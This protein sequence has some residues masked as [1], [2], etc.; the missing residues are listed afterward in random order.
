VTYNDNTSSSGSVPT[1][2]ASYYT[3]QTVP[4]LSN[5]GN[6][7][8]T[9]YSFGGWN[10]AANGSGTT[11]AVGETFSMGSGNTTLYAYWK[12]NYTQDKKDYNPS[13]TQTGE[14]VTV[15][16]SEADFAATYAQN[17]FNGLVQTIIPAFFPD[18][19]VKSSCT[20]SIK[21]STGAGGDTLW[22]TNDDTGKSYALN[23]FDASGKISRTD[24][25]SD[26]TGTTRTGYSVYTLNGD[27]TYQKVLTY[28]DGDVLQ[29]SVYFIFSSGLVTQIDQWSGDGTGT[30][31]RSL[32]ITYD[33]SN[34]G[35][36]ITYQVNSVNQLQLVFGFTGTNV[37]NSSQEIYSWSGSDWTLQ[38][39]MTATLN[40]S[41][42]RTTHVSLSPPWGGLG[43]A[44]YTYTS[45]DY[46]QQTTV[47][48]DTAGTTET[49]YSVYTYN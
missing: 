20:V 46:N 27:G 49:G 12:Q 44:D 13:A 37:T 42:T 41:G 17:N 47:Y 45:S 19:I 48:S 36:N 33:T 5:S 38:S 23:T 11:Y 30:H 34:R 39:T 10:T 21:S 26:Y 16:T 1:D 25:Y 4:V 9:G 7:K 43:A 18:S 15:F 32:T 3:G 28:N 22:M 29:N 24:V 2:P 8:K 40:G 6:L 14:T 35:T 31:L